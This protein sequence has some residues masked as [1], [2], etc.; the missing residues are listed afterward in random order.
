MPEKPKSGLPAPIK[1][2]PSSRHGLYSW[3]NSKAVPSGRAAQAIRRDLSRTRTE[4]VQAHG[5]EKISPDALILV[6]SV[7]EALGV[8]KLCGL[9]VRKHG[10]VDERSARRGCLE[11]SP[12][13]GKNWISYANLVRQGILALREIDKDRE[14]DDAPD[15]GAILAEYERE[16]AARDKAADGPGSA[17]EG[18]TTSGESE[19]LGG[20][21]DGGL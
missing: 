20:G 17:Q 14:K 8:Q 11:L 6:D 9:H 13:L 7:V 16:D 12:V 21:A 2:R 5:G 4:L 1:R 15:M 10:V 19:G 18:R 3:V